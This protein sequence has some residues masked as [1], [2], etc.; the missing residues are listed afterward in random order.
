[1]KRGININNDFVLHKYK[2]VRGVALISIVLTI[3]SSFTISFTRVSLVNVS[4]YTILKRVTCRR[5]ALET[6]LRLQPHTSSSKMTLTQLDAQTRGLSGWLQH[7]NLNE[8]TS[9][10]ICSTLPSVFLDKSSHFRLQKFTSIY[11]TSISFRFYLMLKKWNINLL[12]N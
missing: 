4:R 5:T 12:V 2:H 10:H 1:M 3:S 7:D 9:L 11:T 6:W 8:T